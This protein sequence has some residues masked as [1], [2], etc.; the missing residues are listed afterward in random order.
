MENP[1]HDLPRVISLLASS[2]A[3]T[4]LH[5]VVER[6]Y[7]PDASLRHP[8]SVV[9]SGPNSRQTLLGVYEWHRIISPGTTVTINEL[10]ECARNQSR[11][12]CTD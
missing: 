10:G 2:K 12:S 3:P 6:F 1:E 11:C 9:K 4:I 8:F 5:K 7:T